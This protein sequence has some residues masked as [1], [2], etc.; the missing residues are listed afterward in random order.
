MG[1][2]T[3]VSLLVAGRDPNTSAA[4]ELPKWRLAGGVV[5]PRLEARRAREVTLFQTP[6]SIFV[7]PVSC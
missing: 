4:T 1:T 3:L 7:L 5:D 2:S 6:S